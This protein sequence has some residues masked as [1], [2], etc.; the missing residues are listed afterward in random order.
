MVYIT[1]F[2]LNLI[3]I[4]LA[5]EAYIAL[6]II[7]KV[8]I[9]FKYLDF[10]DIFLEEKTLILLETI[11]LNQHTIKLQKAYQL[12]YRPIYSLNLVELEILKTY[13]KTNL[14]NSF[15]WPLKSLIGALILFI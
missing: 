14:A 4:H 12:P 9:L 13:I 6:L 2:S 5:Q 11:D 7:K 3:L 1:S 8:Q 10:L 15:I